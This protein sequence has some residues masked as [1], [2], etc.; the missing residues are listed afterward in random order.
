MPPRYAT[1][2]TWLMAKKR[3]DGVGEREHRNREG[4]GIGAK[5]RGFS[6]NWVRAG[7]LIWDHPISNN[8]ISLEEYLPFGKLVKHYI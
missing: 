5:E 2:T 3:I 4:R 8:R 1:D 6:E 7:H